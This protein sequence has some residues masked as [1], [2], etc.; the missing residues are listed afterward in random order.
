MPDHKLS[1]KKNQPLILLRN[2]RP[3]QGL[4]NGTKL[5]CRNLHRYYIEAEIAS[6]GI[7]AG[8]IVLIPRIKLFGKING[9]AIELS[10][11]QFPVRPAFAMTINKSQG[12]T[13]SRVGVYL[14]APVFSHGQLYVAFSRV[15]NYHNLQVM[16]E[17]DEDTQSH[18]T[19]NIVYHEVLH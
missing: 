16:A 6:P 10:R 14:T 17:Y 19:K 4:C 3:D 5:I 13:L 12:Q 18:V 7:H 1:L 15:T 11:K 2:L 8:T 9:T